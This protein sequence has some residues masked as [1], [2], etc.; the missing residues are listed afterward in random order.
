MSNGLLDIRTVARDWLKKS[1]RGLRKDID[2]GVFGPELIRLGRSVR[3]RA[4][5]LDQWISA[6]CPPRDQWARL[7]KSRKAGDRG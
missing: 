4:M 6:G 5:E 1:E 2:C 7:R 3:V